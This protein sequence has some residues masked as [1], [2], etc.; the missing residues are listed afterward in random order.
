MLAT[1]S[2]K[3]TFTKLPNEAWGVRITGADQAPLSGDQ[4]TV[5]T[6]AGEV[7]QVTIAEVLETS[8]SAY[9]CSLRPSPKPVARRYI[10]GGYFGR[11]FECGECGDMVFNGSYCWET[12][13]RH[14]WNNAVRD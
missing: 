10:K 2:L 4:V 6:Q 1:S 7:R 5:T 12:G 13:L 3:A 9:V 8:G 14:G 11:R